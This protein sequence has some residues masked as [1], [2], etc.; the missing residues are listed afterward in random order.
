MPIETLTRQQCNDVV[1]AQRVARLACAKNGQPYVVP[2]CYASEG[3]YLYS[4]SLTG[5]KIDWRRGEPKVCVEVTKPGGTRECL[6]GTPSSA[7]L[8]TGTRSCL[9]ADQPARQ[10]VGAWR[11]R[12]RVPRGRIG[13]IVVANAEHGF[14]CDKRHVERVR[15][16]VAETT[17]PTRA[18]AAALAR[19]H[20]F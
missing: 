19:T 18:P 7:A 5:Q 3:H 17:H 1:S 10:L 20:H 11:P 6:P 16:W 9:V 4:F 8:R 15:R 12:T 14:G 13:V 2:I